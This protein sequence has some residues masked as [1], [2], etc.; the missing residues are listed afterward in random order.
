MLDQRGAEPDMANLISLGLS[1]RET[2][3]LLW[4]ARGKTDAWKWNK[5]AARSRSP[6]PSGQS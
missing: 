6:A 1:L 3:V 2:E 5:C 4:V